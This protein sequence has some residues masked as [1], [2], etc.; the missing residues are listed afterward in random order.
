MFFALLQQH[1]FVRKLLEIVQTKRN[2]GIA[3][4]GLDPNIL[5]VFSC[6]QINSIAI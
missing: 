4:S 5:I 1:C 2:K 6:R 3:L